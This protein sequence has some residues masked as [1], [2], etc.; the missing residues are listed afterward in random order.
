MNDLSIRVSNVS[1]EYTLGAFG[2]ATLKADLQTKFA[3]V[4]HREDPN[5][6]IDADDYGANS[7]FLALDDVSFDI[8]KGEAVGIIGQ[9]GAGK[10]T[11]LKLICRIT[12]PTKGSISFNGRITSML[13][14]G[15]G[16]HPELTG[17]ENIY[18]N[19]AILG[20]KKA[21]ITKKIDEIVSFSEVE[22]FI[23][24]PIKR[25]SSGMKVKLAF[26]VASHLNSE[27]MIMDEVL[28][29][30]DVAFQNKCIERMKVV[31]REEGRTVLYVSHNMTTVKS[32]CNRCIVLDHGQKIFEG[33]TPEA[34]GVYM[35]N[36]GIEGQTHFDLTD[37][38]RRPKWNSL[39]HVLKNATLMDTESSRYEY[40]EQIQLQIQWE[41][42]VIAPRLQVKII[43]SSVDTTPA[44]VMFAG[45]V[46]Q[47]IGMNSAEFT[48]DTK[49][50]VPG[51]YSA[52]IILYDDDHTGNTVFHDW[53][54]AFH[55]SVFESPI[56]S[57]LKEW[58][59]S[60]GNTVLP[61]IKLRND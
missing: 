1:K 53:C 51:R 16:F 45:E 37:A 28:A 10:S 54:T 41:S 26:A 35:K 58:Y 36:T 52:D 56:S 21:E 29:V 19:G 40:G 31:S 43:F 48:I 42:K 33:N 23:D 6:K 12:A 32:L 13:E 2:K 15:T 44:G 27:I 30:G 49:Y 46:P 17:R 25:Y 18:L 14:V 9:N 39:L 7:R 5:R 4:M 60:W 55:F 57:H 24:T 20:M 59:G 61:G 50:F 34:I 22:K 11:I 38:W 47:K 8:R 3:K